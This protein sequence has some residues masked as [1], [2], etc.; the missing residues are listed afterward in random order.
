MEEKIKNLILILLKEGREPFFTQFG[1]VMVMIFS[2][3]TVN[4]SLHEK[5]LKKLPSI[6]NNQLKLTV[7]PSHHED[8]STHWFIEFVY[9]PIT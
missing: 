5:P 7:V 9:F 4:T 6:F 2:D 3:S 8:Q 1:L